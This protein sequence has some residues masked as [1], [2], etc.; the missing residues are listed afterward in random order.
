MISMK[1]VRVY[2][3]VLVSL[4][5]VSVAAQAQNPR[6]PA[7]EGRGANVPMPPYDTSVP[8]LNLGPLLIEPAELGRPVLGV[9]FIA[10]A[11]TEI[12]RAVPNGSAGADS[13]SS[14]AIARDSQ[15]R[16]RREHVA[17]A[18]GPVM[19]R[20]TV[21]LVTITDPST[22]EQ[23]LIDAERRTALRI[24]VGTSARTQRQAADLRTPSPPPG[25]EARTESL[26]TRTFNGLRAEGTRTTITIGARLEGEAPTSLVSE[27]WYS[28]ELQVV[29]MTRRS[30]PRFGDTTYR[31][32]NIVRTEPPPES[33]EI[34]AG[35]AV[36][37]GR[38]LPPPRG[39]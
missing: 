33:F 1:S 21:P 14:V 29:V 7:R 26:G 34:P 11:V 8:R 18:L 9:P 25:V 24:R 3:L 32:T 13:R 15:G 16:I 4:S 35:F 19:A 30:D 31:L 20:R 5:G 36:R 12:T 10:E 38:P 23:L 22:G 39:R 37:N 28:P 27:R 2:A 17:V 6:Q